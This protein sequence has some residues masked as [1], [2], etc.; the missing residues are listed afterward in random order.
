MVSGQINFDTVKATGG[1]LPKL[2]HLACVFVGY[3]VQISQ[4]FG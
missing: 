4:A 3:I 1:F 2:V